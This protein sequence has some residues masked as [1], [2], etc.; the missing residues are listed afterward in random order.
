MVGK[1]TGA[2]EGRSVVGLT[3]GAVN[4][5]SVGSPLR[6]GADVGGGMLKLPTA[7]RR[8]PVNQSSSF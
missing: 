7:L 8:I 1:L 6:V 3:L 4:G 2:V 5:A